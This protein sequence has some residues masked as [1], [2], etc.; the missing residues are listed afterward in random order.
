MSLRALGEALK[1]SARIVLIAIIPIVLMGVDMQGK[2]VQ[3]D[4]FL[5]Q[6]TAIV[7]FL[8][9][10]DSWLHQ[11]GKEIGNDTMSKGLVRF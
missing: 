6:F 5:V 1:E 7:S 2:T 4:W 8:R 9:F 10:A 11:R 3:I